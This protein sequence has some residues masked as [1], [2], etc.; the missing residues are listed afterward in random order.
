MS[1]FENQSATVLRPEQADHDA[2]E[3]LKHGR[4]AARMQGVDCPT[5]A[6]LARW[7]KVR[8][9]RSRTLGD[10]QLPRPRKPDPNDVQLIMPTSTAAA[11][12]LADAGCGA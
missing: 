11:Q 6:F 7:K 8:L 3:I 5:L 2:V 10:I 1:R 4:I 9:F 12:P